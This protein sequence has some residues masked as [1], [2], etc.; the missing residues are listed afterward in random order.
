VPYAVPPDASPDAA[1]YSPRLLPSRA[2]RAGVAFSLSATARPAPGAQASASAAPPPPG[3]YN[4]GV[5]RDLGGAFKA[6][7]PSAAF[8]ARDS[9][10]AERSLGTG[11]RTPGP[12]A[13]DVARDVLS[14]PATAAAAPF[15]SRARR[16]AGFGGGAPAPAADPARASP[17]P[18]PPRVRLNASPIGG[19]EPRFALPPDE[20][21][22]REN[23]PPGTYSIA[24]ALGRARP[25]TSAA[26]RPPSMSSSSPMR[27]APAAEWG[28][29]PAAAADAWLRRGAPEEGDSARPA[30]ARAPLS[31]SPLTVRLAP[32]PLDAEAASPTPP[33][34]SLL[35]AHEKASPS[36]APA[37]PQL[38]LFGGLDAE[39][40]ARARAK[41]TASLEAAKAAQKAH[42]REMAPFLP[43]EKRFNAAGEAGLLM[44][45]GAA[46]REAPPMTV[47]PGPGS[48]N[49]AAPPL[50]AA[51]AVFGA[52]SAPFSVT[53][54]RSP[55]SS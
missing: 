43:P 35:W 7:T 18:P 15:G 46:R 41:L 39:A 55:P 27:A 17:P 42:A 44:G 52:A 14:R 37:P 2:P 5:P 45:R 9:D 36:R 53:G 30:S 6:V 4:P 33:P 3:A 29:D 24:R 34:V 1:T 50:S 32:S 12:G 54:R 20:R 51:P 22:L 48:F 13:Y 10:G 19:S 11:P 28:R 25:H 16:D 47:T 31:T 40:Q 23:P 38:A 26:L 8:A 21:Q 49:I